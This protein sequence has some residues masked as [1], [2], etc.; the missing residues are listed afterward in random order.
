MVTECIIM[1]VVGFVMLVVGLYTIITDAFYQPWFS[2]THI[3][4]EVLNKYA[5]GMGTGS[6]LIG[7]GTAAAGITRFFI[8]NEAVWIIIGAGCCAGLISIAVTCLK[9]VGRR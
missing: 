7:L 1:I 2:R 6:F 8:Q 3:P 9:Y 5:D 4:D